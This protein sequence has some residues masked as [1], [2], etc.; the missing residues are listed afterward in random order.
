MIIAGG[1]KVYPREVE[2]V[3]LAHP[4]VEEAVAIGVPDEYRGESVKV[5]VVPKKG[6]VVNEEE[7][8]AFARQRLAAYK[9]FRSLEVRESLPK[10][11][12]GKVLRR[13]LREG[14]G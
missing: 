3:L 4:S 7:L 14:K 1:F 9:I 10:T 12:A 2:E 6:E 13:L 11:A 5:F 8:R